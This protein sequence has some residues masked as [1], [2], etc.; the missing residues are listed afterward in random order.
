LT[1]SDATTARLMGLY[2]RMA[3]VPQLLAGSSSQKRDIGETCEFLQVSTVVAG[4]EFFA[5]FW[6]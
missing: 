5:S 3:K 2:P 4:V 1:L 6:T